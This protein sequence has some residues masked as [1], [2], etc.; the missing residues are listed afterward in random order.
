MYAKTGDLTGA[1]PWNRAVRT[2]ATFVTS[3]PIIELTA[4]GAGPGETV[5]LSPDGGQVRVSARLRSPRGLGRIEIV[6]NGRAVSE[7]IEVRREGG[8]QSIAQETSLRFEKSGWI[9]A[10]G[11]GERG[12]VFGG[13]AVA[14]TAAIRVLVGGAP[15]WSESDGEALVDQ[16][17]EQKAFYAEKGRYATEGDR[18]QVMALFDRAID[19]LRA[20]HEG[21]GESDACA[22]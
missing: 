11:E 20:K 4:E 5:C 1:E 10:R 17:D 9:A 22:Q 16:I 2:G 19:E 14:H 6:Q 13:R 18:R 21:G 12:G 15:I 3:G 7:S 8:I